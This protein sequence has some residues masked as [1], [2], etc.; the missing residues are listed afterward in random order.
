MA[1]TTIWNKTIQTLIMS[2]ETSGTLLG[3]LLVSDVLDV[4]HW[5]YTRS[6]ACSRYELPYLEL[7]NIGNSLKE[8]LRFNPLFERKFY[9]ASHGGNNLWNEE[10]IKE[11]YVK[12]LEQVGTVASSK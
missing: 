8:Q 5:W 1:T 4:C 7:D 9:Y 3:L 10:Y 12:H 6:G 11:L 2:G